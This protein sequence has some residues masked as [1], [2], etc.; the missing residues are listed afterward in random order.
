M[1]AVFSLLTLLFAPLYLAAQAE[2]QTTADRPPQPAA[3]KAEAAKQEGDRLVEA[4]DLAGAVDA[5]GR[6]LELDSKYTAAY[7]A[8]GTA[9][10]RL[11][12][13]DRALADFEAALQLDPED[14]ETYLR[15]GGAHHAL[16]QLDAAIQDYDTAIEK[17]PDYGRAYSA[18]GG[19]KSEA[20]DKAGAQADWD[21]AESLGFGAR[22]LR[23][24]GITQFAKLIRHPAPVYPP[25]AKAARIT[26]TVRL[27]AVIGKDGRIQDLTLASGHPLL[28]PAAMDAVRQWVY[29]P[30]LLD[31]RPVEIAT[32]IDVTFTLSRR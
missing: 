15:R 14:A 1:K 16:H 22:R 10:L 18:R 3:S 23:V 31:G 11:R 21:K 8:R 13:P 24:G 2:P 19:V 7:K 4:K 27:H 29:Q 9:F 5:Y 25:E 28:A 17:K 20:G 12:Q 6:A 32:E 30:T 26:G